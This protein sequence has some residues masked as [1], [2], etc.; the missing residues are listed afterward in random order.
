MGDGSNIGPVAFAL[1]G[2]AAAVLTAALSFAAAWAI[3]RGAGVASKL[4]RKWTKWTKR[5]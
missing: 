4:Y 1:W 5:P 3:A 2:V